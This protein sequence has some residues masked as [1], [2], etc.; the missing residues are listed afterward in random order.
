MSISIS[1]RS[2]GEILSLSNDEWTMELP[3]NYYTSLCT[4]GLLKDETVIEIEKDKIVQMIA[5]RV[6]SSKLILSLKNSSLEVDDVNNFQLINS[7]PKYFLDKDFLSGIISFGD[8]IKIHCNYSSF[9]EIVLR[10]RVCGMK[11][12][13]RM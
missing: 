12:Y 10:E 3:T 11:V 1:T 5:S 13:C 7:M 8:K 4:F 2:E 9:V 6:K